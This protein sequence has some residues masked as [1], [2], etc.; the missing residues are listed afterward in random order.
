MDARTLRLLLV[1]VAA[2]FVCYVAYENS[3]LGAAMAVAAA[4]AT[5][6]YAILKGEDASGE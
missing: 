1:L 6:L 4:V 3:A 2:A 5:A